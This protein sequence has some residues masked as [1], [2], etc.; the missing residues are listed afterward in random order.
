M[1][2]L[3]KQIKDYY[4]NAF[5]HET[6]FSAIKDRANLKSR[7]R[8][9]FMKSKKLL[10]TISCSCIL[11]ALIACLSIVLINKNPKTNN[12]AISDAVINLDLNPSVSLAVDEKG[13]VTAV[14]G[15]NDEGKM[16]IADEEL[17]GKD[18]ED[19]LSIIVDIETKCGF[20]VKASVNNDYNN[21]SI[22]I[23]AGCDDE[24]FNKMQ[25]EIKTI[26]ET[27]LN[28][29]GIFVN[30]KITFV[31][32]TTKEALIKKAMEI[33][34]NLTYEDASNLTIEQLLA[35]ITA[36]Y[37]EV[38]TLPTAEIEEMYNSFKK[39]EINLQ[40]Y[41]LINDLTSTSL[42]INA[43]IQK[44]YQELYQQTLSYLNEL[45][46]FYNDTFVD[47]SSEY[48]QILKEIKDYKAEVLKLR[49]EVESLPDGIEKDLKQIKLQTA[50][51][52]LNTAETA[53]NSLKESIKKTLDTITKNVINGLDALNDYIMSNEELEKL[54]N[55]NIDSINKSLNEYKDQLFD[56]FEKNYKDE[57]INSYNELKK[58]KEQLIE[59]L[60]NK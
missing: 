3:E 41:K 21:L 59:Q 1:K 31:K 12:T 33:D 32:N 7:K 14:Y 6:N 23:N 19:A 47:E 22:T 24:K 30:D 55:D 50:N 5:Y 51:L 48:Q 29:L 9:N 16:I 44:R 10:I 52:S 28:E 57:I 26:I 25:E 58:Q 35:H 38:A 4:D 13:E 45:E 11:V 53:L 46:K 43:E 60:K 2:K 39:Y 17:V 40:N 18:V 8:Y 34:P 20:F 54:I 49:N 36:Y 15:N 27:K 42:I 37:L 56:E